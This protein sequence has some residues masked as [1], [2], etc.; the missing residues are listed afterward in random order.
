MALEPDGTML[1]VAYFT[2]QQVEV[3]GVAGLPYQAR[4]WL[5]PGDG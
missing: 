3:V 2:S 5:S 1:L 4:A